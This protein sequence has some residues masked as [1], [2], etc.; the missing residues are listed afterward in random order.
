MAGIT[1]DKMKCFSQKYSQKIRD[2]RLRC[3]FYAVI[4]YWY[5]WAL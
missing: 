1:E 5:W 3:N 2:Q 4:K